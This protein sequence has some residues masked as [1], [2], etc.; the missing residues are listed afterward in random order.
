[1]TGVEKREINVP[2]PTLEIQK[3]AVK[4]DEDAFHVDAGGGG[5]GG[6]EAP[7]QPPASGA[8]RSPRPQF[9]PM[10]A[11][12]LGLRLYRGMRYLQGK[13]WPAK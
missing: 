13:A 8:T 6:G 9:H 4:P 5:G 12:A 3:Q 1:V 7:H 11:V 2:R 10:P